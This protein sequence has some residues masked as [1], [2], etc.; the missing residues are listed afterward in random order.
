MGLPSASTRRPVLQHI[1]GSHH[2][3]IH[4]LIWRRLFLRPPPA[5]P[6][7]QLAHVTLLDV[8]GPARAGLRLRW[9]GRTRHALEM[10]RV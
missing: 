10:R 8:V 1:C 6:K 5:S 7:T 2:S 9:T 3:P 4:N